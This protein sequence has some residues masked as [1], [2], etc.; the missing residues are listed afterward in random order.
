MREVI[1]GEKGILK[2]LRPGGVVR[3]PSYKNCKDFTSF[4]SSLYVIDAVIIGSKA[5]ASE[6]CLFLQFLST[7]WC[8][9]VV[10]GQVVDMT[11]SEPS[12]A[13]EIFAVAQ[14]KYVFFDLGVYCVCIVFIF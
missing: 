12:L 8:N 3:T 6:F 1:L 7:F 10:H 2:G 11:T 13:R 4:L 5:Q 14:E 9:V